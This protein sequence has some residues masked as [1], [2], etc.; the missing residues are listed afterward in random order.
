MPE[1]TDE[2]L[3][4]LHAH[5]DGET[6]EAE[7]DEARELLEDAGAREYF[8]TFLKMRSL[9]KSHSA[10][11]APKELK[12]SVLANIKSEITAEAPI[13][14]LPTASWWAP[15]IGVAAAILL[16]LAV[17]FMPRGESESP[18]DVAKQSLPTVS[19][20]ASADESIEE[21]SRAL[22][23]LASEDAPTDPDDA[24]FG[25][26][27]SDLRETLDV[28]N[29]KDSDSIDGLVNR[30]KKGKLESRDSQP[31]NDNA[32]ETEKAESKSRGTDRKNEPD[33]NALGDSAE[34]KELDKERDTGN[35]R[36]SRKD[37]NEGSDPKAAPKPESTETPND[38]VKA[39]EEV[40]PP[41]AEP[42]KPIAPP[43]PRQQVGTQVVE[44]ASPAGKELAA[45]ADLLWV[46]GLYGQAEIDG[47]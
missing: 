28:E 42:V 22:D 17:T 34:N 37:A 15:M 7:A 18:A 16:V 2:Q 40:A 36:A 27:E 8:D 25:Q 5:L 20:E 13:H 41:A 46:S 39:D 23:E 33:S 3:K 9:V 43:E 10:I 1:L 14:Q 44:I 11:P 32:P 4:L 29:K 30:L 31:Q 47:E 24:A 6:N 45:Q 12:D 21:N 35:K 26:P 38:T 19:D